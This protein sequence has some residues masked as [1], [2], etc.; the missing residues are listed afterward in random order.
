MAYDDE[1]HHPLSSRALLLACR[2]SAFILPIVIG[3]RRLLQFFVS[4]FKS[5]FL[6]SLHTLLPL[7][8]NSC[9]ETSRPLGLGL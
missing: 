2:S 4:H 5:D 9:I 7:F 1:S 6:D 3:G 8:I